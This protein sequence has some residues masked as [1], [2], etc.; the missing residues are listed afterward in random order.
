MNKIRCFVYCTTFS[1]FVLAG[2][3]V[4]VDPAVAQEANDDQT[5]EVIEEVF[6]I[7]ATKER[8]FV[9]RPN[10]LGARTKVFRI[11]RQVSVADL[12]L[13]NDADVIELNS[14]IENTATELCEE[15]AEK[16]PTP[17]WDRGDLRRCIVEA[18]ESTQDELETITAALQ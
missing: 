18:I 10:E 15:L 14:R 1:A 9:R 11:K 5:S 3:L 12:D 4:S 13:G 7:D 16:H 17:V 8:R 6:K 2:F